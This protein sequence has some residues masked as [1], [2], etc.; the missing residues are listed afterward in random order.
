MPYE[1]SAKTNLKAACSWIFYDR[2]SIEFEFRAKSSLEDN[3]L[4]F[5]HQVMRANSK[6]SN[7]LYRSGE[8]GKPKIPDV[9][10]PVNSLGITKYHSNQ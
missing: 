8:T 9:I 1:K 6:V 10:G 4:P 3:L 7:E 2:N 5:V